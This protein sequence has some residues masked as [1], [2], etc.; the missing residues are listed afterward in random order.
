MS[1]EHSN[2]K[3]GHDATA[4]VDETW[5]RYYYA[6]QLAQCN[7]RMSSLLWRLAAAPKRLHECITGG[8]EIWME[9]QPW[10]FEEAGRI[11]KGNTAPGN[12]DEA[13]VDKE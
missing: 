9:L 2:N 12:E 13:A 7:H 5:D 10:I 11:G 3:D 6:G 4:A 8:W 1:G